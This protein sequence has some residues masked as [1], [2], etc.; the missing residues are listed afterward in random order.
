MSSPFTRSL[1]LQGRVIFAL[2]L[3]EIQ[4]LHGKS[5]LGYLWQFFKTGMAVGIFW[6]IRGAF[7]QHAPQ[8]IPFPLML[9]MGFIPWF[10]FS[11]TVTKTVEAVSTNNALLTFPQVT[12]LD[13]F[14]SSAL[15]IWVTELIIMAFYLALLAAMGFTFRLYAPLIF[16][17][18]L[19]GLCLFS[20]GL[21]LTLGAL[22]VY[23]PAIE[24]FLPPVLRVLFLT[25][26]VFFSP[27]QL[28]THYSRFL[29]MNPITNFIEILRHSFVYPDIAPVINLTML[30]CLTFSLLAAGLLLERHSRLKQGH[31]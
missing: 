11:Q 18:C 28:G 12:P 8:S 9:V 21:G 3:R 26:G 25:S 5:R 4:T 2:A 31:I 13:L 15:V 23:F 24:K 16:L 19:A 29:Y 7:G 6:V 10:L 30:V 14:F 1:R 27:T 17:T 22:N 20:L